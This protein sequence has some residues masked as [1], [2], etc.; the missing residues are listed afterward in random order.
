MLASW[1]DDLSLIVILLEDC[2][3]CRDASVGSSTAF[4]NHGFAVAILLLARHR[5]GVHADALFKAAQGAQ[6]P[7][8]HTEGADELDPSQR[9]DHQTRLMHPGTGFLVRR[10]MATRGFIILMAVGCSRS[11]R[12]SSTPSAKTLSA[13][14]DRGEFNIVVHEPTGTTP[15]API[16]MREI[17]R[18]RVV[19]K[20]EC[21]T[22]YIDGQS[23]TRQRQR[24]RYS[25]RSSGDSACR[26]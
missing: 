22:A 25:A 19:A 13:V 9:H 2:R 23:G 4:R 17:E 15:R 12:R 21:V 11:F 16:V 18:E 20:L 3:L 26:G 7:A 5:R 14:D 8:A 6:R 24:R 10:S 1:C